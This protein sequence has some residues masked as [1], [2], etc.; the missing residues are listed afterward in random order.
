MR[1]PLRLRDPDHENIF[2]LFKVV[3]QICFIRMNKC[4]ILGTNDFNL[5]P[6]LQQELYYFCYYYYNLVPWVQLLLIKI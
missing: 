3:S 2:Q 5:Q 4:Y 1:S 6:V